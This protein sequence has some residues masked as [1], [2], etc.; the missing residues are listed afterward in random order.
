MAESKINCWQYMQCGREP[1]G[2]NVAAQGACRAATDLS[3]DGIHSGKC[4]GRFCWAVGGTFCGG[5]VQ[6]TFAKKRDLC[7]KCHFYQRVQAEEGTANLRTKFLR[8]IQPGGSLLKGLE[9][10]H[11][12]KGTRFLHQGEDG[13]AGYIIQ[14]GACMKLVE[15]AG[16]LHPADHF[17]EGDVVGF[18]ALLT[19]EPQSGHMEAETDMEVW[20]VDKRRLDDLSDKDHELMSFLTEIVADRFDSRRPIAKRSI[21]PYVANEIVG[22]GGYSIVYKGIRP[23]TQQS[24]AIK[25]LR[26]HMALNPDF[27]SSFHREARVISS[28]RHDHIIQVYDIAE[29]YRTVF[30]I[31]EYLEGETVKELLAKRKRFSPADALNLLRQACEAAAHAHSMGLIHRDLNPSNMMVL[32]QGRL[33]LIDFGLACPTGTDDLEFGGHLAYQ[34]PELLE[35]KP[36]D[37]RSDVYAL[38]ITAYEMICGRI[39]HGGNDIREFM[40]RRKTESIPDPRTHTPIIPGALQRFIVKACRKDPAQRYTDARQ[41]LEDLSKRTAP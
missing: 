25:M 8:F 29:R 37:E 11:I 23:D 1:G 26:H 40:L 36:A 31:M 22:R 16:R 27:L 32:P 10:R 2:A 35:G 20:V 33:K 13:R 14:R 38:G 41:A 21:G 34:A 6:G 17:N 7:T 19:G 28:L 30:I 4:A 12:P 39:P 5:T 15:K 24:V 3:Y 18:I 9:Y